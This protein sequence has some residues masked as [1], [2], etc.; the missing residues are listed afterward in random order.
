[1][2]IPSVYRY[3]DKDGVLLYIGM[4]LNAVRRLWQHLGDKS[5]AN[6]V[7][8]IDVQIFPEREIALQSERT[9]IQN[10]HPRYN[11]AMAAIRTSN[12]SD[13]DRDANNRYCQAWRDRNRKAYNAYFRK[14]RKARKLALTKV[15]G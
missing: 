14:W 1:M 7:R 4:S 3:F 13:T 5:W 10:E 6:E 11:L 15:K 12:R 9:A 8:R 2:R